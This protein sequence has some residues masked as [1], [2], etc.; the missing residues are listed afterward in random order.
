MTSGGDTI[1]QRGKAA[2][3]LSQWHAR[4][5]KL[6]DAAAIQHQL[7][8]RLHDRTDTSGKRLL[9]CRWMCARYWRDDFSRYDYELLEKQVGGSRRMHAL[10]ALCF[11]Q[12]LMSRKRKGAFFY[13]DRGLRLADPLL[14]TEDYF[15][16]YNRHQQLRALSLTEQGAAGSTLQALLNE[17]AV[18]EQLKSKPLAGRVFNP[19]PQDTLMS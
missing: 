8:K 10:L 4:P 2:S 9:L 18:I 19:H 3:L 15:T 5:M 16:L 1:K 7:E 13:L 17:A 12:L 14:R 11:G 6:D